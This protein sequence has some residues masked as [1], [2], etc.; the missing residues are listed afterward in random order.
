MSVNTFVENMINL[1]LPQVPLS[2]AFYF[3][4][5]GGLATHPLSCHPRRVFD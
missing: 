1:N 3:K 4:V 5:G 2:R